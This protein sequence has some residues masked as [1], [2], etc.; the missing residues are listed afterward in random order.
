MISTF[1]TLPGL[2]EVTI[3]LNMPDVKFPFPVLSGNY[4]I[5]R[6]QMVRLFA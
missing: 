3:Q 1:L 4:Q 6:F 2:G 5:K